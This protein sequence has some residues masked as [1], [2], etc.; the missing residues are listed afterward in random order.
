MATEKEKE[1][2]LFETKQINALKLKRNKY[3]ANSKNKKA[4]QSIIDFA[5]KGLKEKR[6]KYGI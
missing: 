6:K 1:E 2:I 3:A 4:I 5:E